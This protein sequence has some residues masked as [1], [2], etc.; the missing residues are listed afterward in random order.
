MCQLCHTKKQ[1]NR[2]QIIILEILI[3][4]IFIGLPFNTHEQTK[5]KLEIVISVVL[6]F[7]LINLYHHAIL[8]IIS[9]TVAT[10]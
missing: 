7:I 9:C 1:F 3:I 4:T 6:K 2:C 5:K 8:S 10:L